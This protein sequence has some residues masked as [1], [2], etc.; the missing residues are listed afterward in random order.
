[1]SKNATMPHT[2]LKKKK[3]EFLTEAPRAILRKIK[4]MSFSNRFS[5][6]IIAAS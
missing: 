5:N 3:I 2:H 6:D 1:M 4:C